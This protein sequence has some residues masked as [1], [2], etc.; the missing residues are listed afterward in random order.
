MQP[1]ISIDQVKV[2]DRI[3]LSMNPDG[4]GIWYNVTSIGNYWMQLNNENESWAI[5]TINLEKHYLWI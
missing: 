5:G 1:L 2:G 4:G 3:L